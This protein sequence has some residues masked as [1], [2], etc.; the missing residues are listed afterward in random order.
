MSS[1][2]EPRERASHWGMN[3]SEIGEC[4]F[5]EIFQNVGIEIYKLT[6]KPKKINF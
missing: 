2:N 6:E 4:H 3:S 1:S 5:F